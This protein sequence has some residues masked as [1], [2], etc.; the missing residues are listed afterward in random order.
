M[1]LLRLSSLSPFGRGRLASA[2]FTCDAFTSGK[3]FNDVTLH[4]SFLAHPSRQLDLVRTI[5]LV[6][7]IGSHCNPVSVFQPTLLYDY[8][9]C[10]TT[11]ITLYI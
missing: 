1:V 7:R 9:H 6:Q 10:V 2:R 11:A 4:G 3:R 5:E 8:S